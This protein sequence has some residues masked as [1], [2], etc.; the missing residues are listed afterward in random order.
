MGFIMSVKFSRGA[1]LCAAVLFASFG[2]TSL[3]AAASDYKFEFVK[4]E[5]A[6]TRITDVTVKLIHI[7]DSKLVPEAVIFETKADM[8]P[9]GMKRMTG[10]TSLSAASAEP[11]MYRIRTETGMGG[12]WALTLAA[13]V[14]GEIETVRSTI[15]FDAD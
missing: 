3:F 15:D 13:K 8:G 4:A 2:S 6:G 1:L 10:Q 11:G 12:T 5:P 9:S 14:Q 7:P